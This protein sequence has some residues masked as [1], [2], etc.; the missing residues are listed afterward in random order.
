M[1]NGKCRQGSNGVNEDF[2]FY[3]IF[4]FPLSHTLSPRMQEAAFRAA[5]LK[6]FYLPFELAHEEFRRVLRG[7]RTLVLDGFNVTVPYKEETLRLIDRVSPEARAIG[8]VNTVVKRGSRWVGFN[9]DGVG[10]IASLAEAGF[11]PRGRNVLILGAGGSA[12]AVAYALA[13][14]GARSIAIANRTLFRAQRL[15]AQYRRIFPQMIPSPFPLPLRGRGLKVRGEIDLVVN[16]TAV[17]LKKNDPSLVN[18]AD[19]PKRTLFVDLIY[20]PAET[21]FLRLAR[22][23][24]HRTLNGLGMLLYQGAEAFRLW[25]GKRAPLSVMRK[26]LA[27]AVGRAR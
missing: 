7:R 9:T 20:N 14:N 8:A 19:F 18:P 1:V 24:G 21:R 5:G 17:G 22:K 25:T 10:F 4:G 16:A 3:G 6:A 2:Q 26:A 11:R 12:R 23:S 27:G 15:I 13:K